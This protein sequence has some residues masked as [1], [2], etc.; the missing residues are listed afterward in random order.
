MSKEVLVI[1][2]GVLTALSPYLGLPGD[3][4]TILLIIVGISTA[5]AGFFLRSEAL[6]RGGGRGEHFFVDN[7]QDTFAE[8]DPNET[9]TTHVR[10]Q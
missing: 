10:I 7:R 4:R 2:L 8:S 9:H 1:V 3:W 5:V 6:S